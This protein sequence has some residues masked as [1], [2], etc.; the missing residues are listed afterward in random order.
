[1]SSLAPVLLFFFQS[2]ISVYQFSVSD[3]EVV[4]FRSPE[5]PTTHTHTHTHTHTPEPHKTIP[6]VH[7]H[8]SVTLGLLFLSLRFTDIDAAYVSFCVFQA[9]A[10]CVLLCLLPVGSVRPNPDDLV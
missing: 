10:L 4:R 5:G 7:P 8:S 9:K 2:I 3:K 6:D 1:M